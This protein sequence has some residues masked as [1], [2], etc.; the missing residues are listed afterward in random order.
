M[1]NCLFLLLLLLNTPL[2]AQREKA[3]SL[4]SVLPKTTD[5][6]M[7]ARVLNSLSLELLGLSEYEQAFQYASEALTLSRKIR[8]KRGEVNAYNNIGGAFWNRGKYEEALK[9]YF[10]A[11]E[12]SRAMNDKTGIAISC[13]NVGLVY[14]NLGKYSEALKVLFESLKAGRESGSKS[15]LVNTYNNIGIIYFLQSNYKEALKYYRISLDVSRE[16]GD[17]RG[18]VSAY[19]NMALIYTEEENYAKA[20]DTYLSSLKI[21]EE[22][23]DKKIIAMTYCNIGVIWFNEENYDEAL[24]NH[25]ISLNMMN[26]IGTIYGQAINYIDLGKIDM[27]NKKFNE[28]RKK[29]EHALLLSKESGDREWVKNSYEALAELDSTTGN[30]KGAFE[31]NKLFIASRDSLVN[32]ENTKKTVEA[33]M[34]YEFGIKEAGIKA[35]N[36]KKAALAKAEIE[37]QKILRNVIACAT[38]LLVLASIFSFVFYK[39]KRDIAFEKKTAEAKQQEAE[40]KQLVSEVEMKALRSQMNPHF[41]FNSLQ[42]I[43]RFMQN[44]DIER[45]G[46]YL[47]GFSKL[48][49]LILENSMHQEITLQEDMD[50][51]EL[52]MEMESM[53][54]ADKFDYSF[55]I[56]DGLETHAIMVPPLLLQPFVE[57]AIWHGLSPKAGKGHIAIRVKKNGEKMIK[58]EVEDNGVG[59]N[60]KVTGDKII[61]KKGSLGIA[62]TK[63]RIELINRRNDVRAHFEIVDLTDAEN[64]ALGTKVEVVLPLL[65][66]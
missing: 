55:E 33:R 29:F 50:A 53:R 51:L 25:T 62:I 28:A 45:A 19:N 11:L 15:V 31:Y 6:T 49:R 23:G 42:S 36:D 17:K 65:F 8:F 61:E 26:E 12:L 44:Y 21:S 60:K 13:N 64:N 22:I 35:S 58:F 56:H 7:K 4:I 66:E 54:L 40:L 43:Y 63:E 46:N 57:N 52:Y 47:I 20:L 1:R 14:W 32:E 2:F 48:I 24:K 27:V 5:D 59:R 38:A 41:I 30:W 39:R 16:I 34:E 10:N 37:R 3:D 18:I 9:Y